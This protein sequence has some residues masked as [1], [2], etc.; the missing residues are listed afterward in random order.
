MTLVL[1]VALLALRL[2]SLVQP[3]GADQALYAYVGD[4]IRAGGLP[5]RDAWDQKPPAIHFLY[6][7]L[8]S[9]WASD[10]VVPAADLAAAAVIGWLLY[11]L[12]GL[13]GTPGTGAASALIFLLLSNPA[14]TRVGGI[15]LRSQCET[16]IALAVTAAFLLLMQHGGVLKKKGQSPARAGTRRGSAVLIGGGALFGL[17]FAFKYNAA[18][19]AVAGVAA[20]WLCRRLT[21][22]ELA[23]VAAG[24]SLPALLIPSVF[25][26]EGALR[27]LIDAT[28]LY[29]LEYSGETYHSALDLARYL[30]TF[31]VE[32][33]RFDALWTIGGAGCLVLLAGAIGGRERL[34][35]VVWVAAACASIAINGSRGLPQYFIQANPALALAAGWGGAL[36]WH[37]LRAGT[38]HAARFF[39][40]PLVLVTVV[41]VWRVNQFDKLAVQTIFDARHA[42][43]S[44]PRDAY[45][46]RYDDDRKYSAL[47]GDTL[48]KY[49]AAHSGPADRIFVF[50]FTC[51]AYIEANRASASR[52]FWSRPVIVGFNEG[53][54]GYGIAGL[55]SDLTFNRPTVVALQ[56]R[57]WAP[58]VEDSA[59]FFMKTPTLSGWLRAHYQQASGPEGFDIWLR[60]GSTP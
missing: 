28:V 27:P 39:A 55:L 58:D 12:G 56:Q 50:G 44:I 57:D 32:R 7:G 16:F 11:K 22:R 59:A 35:P 29:N 15:R 3:M 9:L 49:L 17:A 26:I 36:V 19:F 38:G 13:A 4:R 21:F 8:R 43:G 46:A 31:P 23:S 34:V 18:L 14:F 41:A 33:A 5:Y 2:P 53:R 54:P 40:V 30:L 52:F 25:A 37:W 45:L 20:L 1:A 6:A 42:L 47:A 51:A 48:G 60:R 24:F 10:G